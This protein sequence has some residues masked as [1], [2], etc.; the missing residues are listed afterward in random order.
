MRA[1]LAPA[2]CLIALLA[3]CSSG[4]G[5]VSQAP[6][7][8]VAIPGGPYIGVPDVP[9]SFDG[10]KS[11]DPKGGTLAYSWS[12]GDG[13][14]GKGVNPTHVYTVVATYDA[15][16]TVTD[17]SNLTS[18]STATVTVTTPP[19]PP[20]ANVGGPYTG[21]PGVP[22]NFSGGKSTDPQGETLAYAWSFGDGATGT[23]VSPTHTYAAVGTYTISLTVTNAS[24]LTSKSTTTA[25][26][27]SPP[28]PPVANV[29]GPYISLPGIALNFNGNNSTDPQGEML[30]YAWNFGDGAAGTGISPT[31][32]YAAVGVYSVSLSVVNTSNLISTSTT[33]VN[34]GI[35]GP[36]WS[37][38]VHSGGQ[39][40]SDAHVYLM[41]ANNSG[42]GQ[43]SLSLLDGSVTGY[44]DSVGAYILTDSSGSFTLPA[45][46]ICPIN[47]ELYIY[48]AGGT[49]GTF[50][51]P[52][53]GL[54]GV[55]GTCDNKNLSAPV[56]INEVTTIATAYAIAG[57]ATDATHI[58]SSGTALAQTGVTNAFTNAANL[59][60]ISSGA[61]LATTPSGSGT[62]PQTTINTLADILSACVNSAGP[63]STLCSTL[64]SNAKS[65]GSMGMVPDNTASAAINI[66]HNPG[67]NIGALYG[68]TGYTSPFAPAL[69]NQPNDFTVALSYSGGGLQQPYAIAIDGSGNAWITN[70]P[71]WAVTKLS[72]SG[73][74]LSG[75]QGYTGNGI[76]GP[77]G[78]A[79]DIYGNAWIANGGSVTELSNLGAPLSGSFPYGTLGGFI[80]PNM[81]NCENDAIATDA[82]GNAWVTSIGLTSTGS[83]CASVAEFSSSGS[84]LSA[85]SGYVTNDIYQPTGI[86]I[87][88]TGNSWVIN[89][90]H[91]T[92]D[93][94]SKSGAAVS[95]AY[96][97]YTALL[98][99]VGIAIDSSGNVW[100]PGDT[101]GGSS[102]LEEYSNSGIL[103][104]QYTGGGLNS[105]AAIAL[106]GAGNVWIANGPDSPIQ[107]PASIS[108]F[109][110]SGFPL[111]GSSGYTSGGL[112]AFPSAIA[113]DGSGNIWIANG[114]GYSQLY[115]GANK[116]VIELIGAATPVITPI[117][118]GLPVKP[119]VDGTSNLATRP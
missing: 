109:S 23:G 58:S 48:A 53:A 39:T 54:L 119:T 34:I 27:G 77:D 56:W 118:A 15:S 51:N 108:E 38:T 12:F 4:A 86:A 114:N 110:S 49:I 35:N 20:V 112:V 6:Q 63:G 106:D 69:A 115:G 42:Y 32:A 28:Q 91:L 81:L 61:A 41:A 67:A 24:N 18:T 57:F 5:T 11:T 46:Y 87:D 74:I 13:T 10:S 31:H 55:L 84:V 64:F 94:L 113:V 71:N 101:G 52:A 83:L 2:I 8:P 36:A 73:A 16:L 105:P 68:N 19:R 80:S 111:T 102:M 70:H 45:G 65:S 90:D 85:S 30:T 1:V 75:A 98:Y 95:S 29:G 44:S 50:T 93:E 89:S 9:L 60:S 7:P 37:G 100:V 66:A 107:G 92:V 33:T 104:E 78:V 116:A 3:G 25:T 40:I 96:G 47:A 88:G 14:T 17:T 97:Y 72:S 21:L 43:P 79:L 117:A 99:P 59:A 82:S 26:V 103:L 62:V 76:I 22:M